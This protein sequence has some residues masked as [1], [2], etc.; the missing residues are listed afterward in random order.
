MLFRMEMIAEQIEHHG[1]NLL[2]VGA[3]DGLGA[4]AERRKVDPVELVEEIEPALLKPR[5]G[6]QE[7]GYRRD[8]RRP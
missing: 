6:E 4:P 8:R 3:L 7:T 2:L 5:H 1:P